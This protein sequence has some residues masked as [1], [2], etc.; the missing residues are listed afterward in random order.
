MNIVMIGSE[1][2]PYAKTGGLADV[3]GALPKAL[4]RAGHET[5]V[6][7]PFYKTIDAARFGITS[8]NM[9]VGVDIDGHHKRGQLY[10]HTPEKNLTYHFIKHDEYFGREHFYQD[11][12]GDYHDNA[13]RFAFFARAAT[14]AISALG[15]KPD[16][17]H[18]HDWQSAM[19]LYDLRVKMSGNPALAQAR[20]VFTIHNIGYQGLFP[21]EILTRIG[22]DA[23]D[24]TMERLEFWGKVN[25]LKG[26]I[27]GAD[28]VTTVS[29]THAEEILT[30]E[31][32]FGLQGLLQSRRKDVFGIIN[33][34]DE[35][36]WSPET[37]KLIEQSYAA[38]DVSGKEACKTALQRKFDLPTRAATPVIGMVG[39]LTVQKGIDLVYQAL[40]DI[41]KHDVQL[42]ILGTGEEKY[43]ELLKKASRDYGLSM[44]LELAFNNQTAH[45]IEAGSDFFLMPSLY[46]PCGLN[47]MISM[48]YG[49]IPIVRATG[50]LND[51]V[52]PF[53]AQ[54]WS[55]TG[56]KFAEPNSKSLASCIHEAL[57]VWAQPVLRNK[58]I[59]NAMIQDFS[60][61][62]IAYEYV[63]L[64]RRIM[65]Q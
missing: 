27:I 32:G 13:Q 14:E 12:K 63:G 47:Q 33:G 62:H 56:F 9:H 48:K 37:D 6:F 59:K 65:N 58:L 50:G 2:A 53:N 46:E 1:A 41:M 38:R 25:F 18:A 29:K 23:G 19:A 51:T 31:Y 35:E 22:L 45:Q 17:V 34:I 64:Y 24:F 55:G 44:R 5:H 26:G 16:I 36:E 49:T 57:T 28:A 10:E 42:V 20:T 11:R 61:T 43:H 30:D 52:E 7:I 8:S 15:L 40:P 3:L 54:T 60:W 21:P 4:A 39:R